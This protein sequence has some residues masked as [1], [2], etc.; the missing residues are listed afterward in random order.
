MRYYIDTNVLASIFV[1]ELPFPIQD[2]IN[3]S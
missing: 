2:I 3:N 1:N